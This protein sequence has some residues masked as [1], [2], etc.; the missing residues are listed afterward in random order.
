MKR[1]RHSRYDK[2]RSRDKKDDKRRFSFSTKNSENNTQASERKRISNK[3]ERRRKTPEKRTQKP[4]YKNSNSD[5][6]SENT[7]TQTQNYHVDFEVFSKSDTVYKQ[8]TTHRKKKRGFPKIVLPIGIAIILF[9]VRIILA[10]G[11]SSSQ[12]I[13]DHHSNRYQP[14]YENRSVRS[15]PKRRRKRIN[16]AYF[17]I[18]KGNRLREITQLKKDSIINII[19][20]VEVHLFKGFHIFDSKPYPKSPIL[21]SY[22]KYH[23]FYD[24]QETVK[25]Q[26]ISEQWSIM[27]EKMAEN[28]YNG[29]FL[30][31]YPK[32]YKI[33]DLLVTETEFSISTT[34][35][36]VYGVAT[37]VAYKNK[38]HFFQFISKEKE[39]KSPNYNYLRKYLNYYL[40][41]KGKKYSLETNNTPS[42]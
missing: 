2:K 4:E 21:A 11:G 16:A 15:T 13:P 31:Q 1:S 12:S 27:R 28:A 23:F 38:C 9:L 25:N 40:K 41:I 6:I 39:G 29:Y 26:S 36:I 14:V 7:T 37:L 42:S 19:P 22:S 35:N 33:D 17:F 18:G 8:Q 10:F 32:K 34:G 3:E 5:T 20:D 30:Y 24:V